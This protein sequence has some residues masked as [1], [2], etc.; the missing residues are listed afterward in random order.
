MCRAEI[1]HFTLYPHILCSVCLDISL[2]SH[3]F[4]GIDSSKEL[5]PLLSGNPLTLKPYSSMTPIK[6]FKE[7]QERFKSL[8]MRPRV[9]V[10]NPSDQD[11]CSVVEKCLAENLASFFL[12]GLPECEVFSKGM[13]EQY[14]SD[15]QV[16][17]DTALEDAAA[18]G[19]KIVHDGLADV[20]FKGNI[21]TDKL[22]KAVLNKDHGLLP[23]GNVL[24][25][26]TA[27]SQPDYPK[28]LFFSDAAV[29][30]QPTLEQFDAMVRYDVDICRKLGIEQPKVA[31]I[32]F[33]EKVN[34]KFD[35]TISYVAIKENATAGAYGPVDVD[36]PMDAKTA[37]D[38]HSAQVKGI[39]SP[40]TG[41]A[42][43]L[44]F[45]NLQAGNT[46]YKTISL[47]GHA[48]MAGLITGTSRPVVVPSRADSAE[49]KFNS[50]AL[51]C[52][53]A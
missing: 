27:V 11:T 5:I 51:A 34:E 23:A 49:S 12:V 32:H 47:F 29:I 13:A 8:P 21:N 44:V 30:P 46:F 52:V 36:G 31:L 39:D 22:L 3:I 20:L 14:P 28:L 19:V 16:Y 7:L 33:S 9:V 15:V 48:R 2:K 18:R 42:D 6:N 17:T 43:I 53:T 40:V 1:A 24:S 37:C 25:H 35:N 26:I 4:V 10:V 45:A 38:L 41:Q 50:L